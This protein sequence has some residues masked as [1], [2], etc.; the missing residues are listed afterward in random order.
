MAAV[1][2]ES[3]HAPKVWVTEVTAENWREVVELELAEDQ[4]R[5]LASNVYSLAQSKFDPNARPRAIY[6]DQQLVGFLMYDVGDNKA[7]HRAFIY[8][9]MIDRRHQGKGYGR[10]ALEQAL[11][12]IRATP[13]VTKVSI[14][15]LPDNP[16]KTLYASVGFVEIGRDEDG[17]VIAELAV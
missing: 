11:E 8:R 12:E 10:A 16:V 1:S 15:Y 2:D 3:Q 4:R 5:L 17:E 9:L 6:A 13:G 14:C 7:P